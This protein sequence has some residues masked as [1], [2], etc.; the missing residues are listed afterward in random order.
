[1][2]PSRPPT[3]SRPWSTITRCTTLAARLRS[4][5]RRARDAQHRLLGGGEV[6]QAH[7]LATA[8]HPRL[9]G[10]GPAGPATRARP[11]HLPTPAS[12]THPRVRVCVRADLHVRARLLR[13]QR[14]EWRAVDARA[15]DQAGDASPALRRPRLG[16]RLPSSL[17]CRPRL[18]CDPLRHRAQVSPETMA[19][20]KELKVVH[21]SNLAMCHMKLGHV[22][23]ARYLVVTPLGHVSREARTC[24]EG[25][26]QLEQ[27]H[28]MALLTMALLTMARLP[29]AR[30]T[31]AR[32]ATLTTHYLLLTTYYLLGARQLEQGVGHRR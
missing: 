3:T 16:C 6:A 5:L 1:M 12:C 8:P 27:L 22:Q 15:D 13:G 9:V 7:L 4:P 24:A 31:M 11:R 30:H 28:T 17:G 21:F 25:A 10:L 29:M 20:I 23:K 14:R 32:L 2:R 19:Q 26:R 18:H